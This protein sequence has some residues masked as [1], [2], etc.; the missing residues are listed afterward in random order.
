MIMAATTRKSSR[1]RELSA[2]SADMTAS[3]EQI[4]KALLHLI[5]DVERNGLNGGSR[6][7][8][9]RCDKHT[10]IDDKQVFHIVGSPPFVH[11]RALGVYAHP[12]RPK[13]M[14]AAIQDRTIDADIGR[15]GGGKNFPGPCN[16]VFEHSRAVLADRVVDARRGD[17]V[18]VLEDGIER[19]A[20]MLLRQ[21][22][23]DRRQAEPVA[24][25]PAER[26]VVARPPRQQA[27]GLA[28]NG[29]RHRSDAAAES[30]GVATHETARRIGFVELFAPE[31]GRRRAIAV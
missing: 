7:Y 24:V 21:V 18:A 1:W 4:G 23:A 8:P 20:V 19:D 13:Q 25:E 22:L 26:G 31:T 11:H 12:R 14:P 29:L 27:L 28:G 30:K 2:V 9:A 17:A 3:I 5:G 15:P 6:I 16:A 10:A